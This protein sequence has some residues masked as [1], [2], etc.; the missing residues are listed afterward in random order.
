MLREF[1]LERCGNPPNAVD[2]RVYQVL[3]KS[4]DAIAAEF[5]RTAFPNGL[6]STPSDRHI[7]YSQ[8]QQFL[9]AEDLL[10]ADKLTLELLCELAGPAAIQRKWLYFTEVDT[11]PQ[12]DLQT[13]NSLWQ[14]YSGG[15][16]GFSVQRDIWLGVGKTWDKMW[17]KIGWKNGNNWTRY[18]KSLLGI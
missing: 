17:P 13:I 15:K 5:L 8:L 4:K 18:P 9:A 14:L 12:T 2:G 7:D 10:A 16:F 6:L 1:L 11:I 3:D